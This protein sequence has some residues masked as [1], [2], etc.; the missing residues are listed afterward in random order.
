MV[1]GA[2]VGRGLSNFLLFVFHVGRGRWLDDDCAEG[3]RWKWG[4]KDRRDIVLAIYIYQSPAHTHTSA[5]VYIYANV[6]HSSLF[7]WVD[8][9]TDGKFASHSAEEGRILYYNLLYIPYYYISE[10]GFSGEGFPGFGRAHAPCHSSG[11]GKTRTLTDTHTTH[12]HTYILT[13]THTYAPPQRHTRFLFGPEA[14][15]VARKTR[16][17]DDIGGGVPRW[18]RFI[19]RRIFI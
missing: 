10:R 11:A 13:Y 3:V 7:S 18:I 12:I 16:A 2:V 4:T 5:G 14:R 15:A 8:A 1:R 17:R 19:V 9:I 6:T